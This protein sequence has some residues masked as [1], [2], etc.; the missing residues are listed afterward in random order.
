MSL[1]MS[2]LLAY[3]GAHFDDPGSGP[4]AGVLDLSGML[5][6]G[7]QFANEARMLVRSRMTPEQLQAEEA[8]EEPTGEQK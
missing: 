8:G 2:Q 3:R 4:D 1:S 7:L 6:I 5:H